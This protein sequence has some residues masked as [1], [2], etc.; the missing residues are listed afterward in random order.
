MSSTYMTTIT[1]GPEHI[2]MLGHVNNA[3]WVQ[4]MEQVATEH[5]TRD[6]A[7][8]HVA[9]YIWVVTRHEIEYR[10]NVKEG[11]TVVARTWIPQEPR[12][13]RF[14]RHM[15]FTGPDGK[16]KVAAKSTWA[17]IDRASGRILR[18]PSEVAAPFLD[19]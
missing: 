16:V 4:W 8:D 12:G 7:P 11:E 18:V 10:G 2:D 5:W 19:H 6:A 17:I 9:A 15:E 1:A 14:D 3:V 13:A